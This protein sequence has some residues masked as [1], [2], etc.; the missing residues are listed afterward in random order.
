MKGKIKHGK[1]I[2]ALFLV[3]AINTIYGN[4]NTLNEKVNNV[5][6]TIGNVQIKNF[7]HKFT[8]GQPSDP[9]HFGNF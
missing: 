7:L 1:L 4:V 3:M 5:A 9:S 8:G 2:A 6:E